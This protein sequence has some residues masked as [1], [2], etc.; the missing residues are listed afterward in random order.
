RIP[1]WNPYYKNNE[2]VL[3]IAF[4]IIRL[5]AETS[6]LQQNKTLY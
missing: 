5:E 3:S 2:F 6:K 4:A 1:K